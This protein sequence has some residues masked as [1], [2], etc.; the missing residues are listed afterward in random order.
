MLLSE[1]KNTVGQEILTTSLLLFLIEEHPISTINVK[2][3]K[4]FFT[5]IVLL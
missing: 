3:I 5:N 2:N 1:E 4:I